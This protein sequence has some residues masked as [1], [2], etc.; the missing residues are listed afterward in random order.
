MS[1][2]K[3]SSFSKITAPILSISAVVLLYSFIVFSFALG[4][5]LEDQF[6]WRTFREE[7]LI[8]DLSRLYPDRE[9]IP[10]ITLQLR[11]DIGLS[12]VAEHVNRQYPI[13]W[14]IITHQQRGGGRGAWAMFRLR[15]YY[16]WHY[17]FS[18]LWA[19]DEW[20]YSEW[21]VVLDTYYHII[22]DSG[23]GQVHIILK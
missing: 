7:A 11:G 9:E 8:A 1:R 20:D 6:R 23:D 21:E 13:T 17:S 22:R 5:A 12:R 18:V 19:N 4:N 15:N 10:N 16:D 14:R 2:A 3:K